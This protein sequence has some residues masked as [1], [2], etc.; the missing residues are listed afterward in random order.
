MNNS[1]LFCTLCIVIESL[2]HNT[3]I[4][5]AS[6]LCH[7]KTFN[8]ITHN[9][10]ALFSEKEVRRDNFLDEKKAES[11][12]SQINFENGVKFFS[13]YLRHLRATNWDPKNVTPF[14][15]L[16]C[17][18]LTPLVYFTMPAYPNCIEY[19]RAFGV[20]KHSKVSL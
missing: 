20:C 1:Y 13:A 14:S 6:P 9:Y 4:N 7:Q 3:Y 11:L 5:S 18:R 19:A 17:S 12:C 8:C 2:V 15:K 16:I 10:T